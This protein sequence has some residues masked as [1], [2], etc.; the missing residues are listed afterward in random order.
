[1]RAQARTDRACNSLYDDKMRCLWYG[2]DAEAEPVAGSSGSGIISFHFISL[3]LSI[4]MILFAS[5]DEG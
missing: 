3:C 1:V 2:A 4:S 5:G